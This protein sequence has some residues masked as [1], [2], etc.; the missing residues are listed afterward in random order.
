MSQK[1]AKR[2]D[3]IRY[4]GAVPVGNYVPK[5]L[6][7]NTWWKPAET[8]SSDEERLSALLNMM[9]HQSAQLSFAE[10]RVRHVAD[11]KLGSD[12]REHP[13]EQAEAPPFDFGALEIEALRHDRIIRE[14]RVQIERLEKL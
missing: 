3:D 2:T 11:R 8:G 7:E 14:L 12:G 10:E 13:G 6:S 1:T 4:E 9:R 5:T